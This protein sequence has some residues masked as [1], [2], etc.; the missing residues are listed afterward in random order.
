[1]KFSFR[2]LIQKMINSIPEDGSVS[3][4]LEEVTPVSK[5][6][7]SLKINYITLKVHFQSARK[8]SLENSTERVRIRIGANRYQSLGSTKH[9][10]S[11]TKL[12]FRKNRDKI[13]Y[14]F[15]D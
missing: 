15:C 3:V 7:E 12:N 2:K 9:F 13:K 4:K 11:K 6:Y 1:M 14:D 5:L 8:R 10:R